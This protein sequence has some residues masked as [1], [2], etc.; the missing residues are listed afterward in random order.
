MV[1]AYVELSVNMT[2][3]FLH[4]DIL[5]SVIKLMH[6]VGMSHKILTVELQI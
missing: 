1:E 3:V 2:M 4:H 5:D 6:R